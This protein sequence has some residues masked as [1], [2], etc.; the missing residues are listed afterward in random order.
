MTHSPATARGL[1]ILVPAV[2]LRPWPPLIAVPCADGLG[3]RS[4]ATLTI[5]PGGLISATARPGSR[6][7]RADAL[8]DELLHALALVGFGRVD[9]AL[10]VGRD[11]V[12]ARRTG[13]AGGRRR[14]SSSAPPATRESMMWIFSLRAVGEED[15]LLLRV[16]RERDVPHRAV[17]ERVLA[18]T[19]A[20]FT[21]LPSLREHLDAVVRAVADVDEAVVRRLGA[22]HRVAELLRRRRV[23]VVAG[24][25]SCRRACCRR[26]PS[27]A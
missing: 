15:V 7:D 11:A 5:A 23:R 12:H 6:P 10:R 18:R 27:S 24:R 25:G 19:S 22:V 20:S 13:R 26:R 9:V 8:V 2:R 1:K 14:R 4:H 17:A 21:N 3:Y 16:L